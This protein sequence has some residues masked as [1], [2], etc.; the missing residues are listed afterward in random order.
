MPL[1]LAGNS[2]GPGFNHFPPPY[3]ADGVVPASRGPPALL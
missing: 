2:V 1:R 3:A